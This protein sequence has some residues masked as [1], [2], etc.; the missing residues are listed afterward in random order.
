MAATDSSAP[1]A[2]PRGNLSIKILSVTLAIVPPASLPAASSLAPIGERCSPRPGGPPRSAG[3]DSRETPAGLTLNP[4]SGAITGTPTTAG[5]KS[6]T[7]TTMDSTTPKAE[8][9]IVALS[10]SVVAALSVTTKSLPTAQVGTVYPGQRSRRR[11]DRP[12]HLEGQHRALPAGL[13]IN[14]NSGAITGTPTGP[15]ALASFTV[16]ATDSTTPTTLTATANL[17]ISVASQPLAVTT[18]SLPGGQVGNP[19]PGVT[20]TSIGGTAPIS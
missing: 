18:T 13:T 3:G 16:T 6:F 14:A 1:A 4:N 20:L 8:T 12:R 15:G 10:I 19:Y 2:R 7:V 5:T 17:S 11:P 9:A